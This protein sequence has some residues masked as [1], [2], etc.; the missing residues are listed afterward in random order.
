MNHVRLV[1]NV[2]LYASSVSFAVTKQK[3]FASSAVLILLQVYV[4]TGG[5]FALI[6]EKITVLVL[7]A[8]GVP[9]SLTLNSIV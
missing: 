8:F 5:S 7:E 6:T 1:A 9:A 3:K 2:R 4:R